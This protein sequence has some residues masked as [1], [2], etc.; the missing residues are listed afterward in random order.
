MS[1]ENVEIVRRGYDAFN[2]GDSEGMVTDFAP[3]FEYIPTGTIPGVRGVFRGPGGWIEFAEWLRSGFESPRAEIKLT[4]AGD[5]V[6]AEV[7]LRGRGKQSGVETSWDIWQ[8]WTVRDGAFVRGQ[9]FTS[10]EAALEAVGLREQ[11]NTA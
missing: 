7:T 2:R 5:Q 1:Q 3:D 8:L 9:G 11:R 10:R 4:D 6:L